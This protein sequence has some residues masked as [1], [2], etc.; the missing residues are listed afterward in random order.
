MLLLKSIKFPTL[1][2][3]TLPVYAPPL[4]V[5]AVHPLFPIK[6]LLSLTSLSGAGGGG[7][8]GVVQWGI[9]LKC[10]LQAAGI[11]Y[12]IHTNML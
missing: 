5:Q 11:R 10:V 6:E 12:I 7:G 1:P 4:P 2:T 9:V 3:A 8:G